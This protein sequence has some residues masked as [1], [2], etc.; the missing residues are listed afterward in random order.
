[1]YRGLTAPIAYESCS[2][3][4][5]SEYLRSSCTD[6]Y[7]SLGSVCRTNNVCGIATQRL[8]HR[9]QYS[10]VQILGTDDFTHPLRERTVARLLSG[11]DLETRIVLMPVPVVQ[12]PADG[13]L[14]TAQRFIVETLSLLA[15]TP[16]D[17]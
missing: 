12:P 13:A 16:L 6:P 10:E 11:E 5:H 7:S 17:L 15:E 8:L 14:P 4:S 2:K 1:M 3:H 9:I